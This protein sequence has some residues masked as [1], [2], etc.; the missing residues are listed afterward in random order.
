MTLFRGPGVRKDAT[1]GTDAGEHRKAWGNVFPAAGV[2]YGGTV[3]GTND[4]APMTYSLAAAGFALPGHGGGMIPAGNDGPITVSTTPAPA[5]GERID[6]VWVKHNDVDIDP[7]SDVVIGCT[8]GVASGSAVAPT[9]PVRALELARAT[10]KAGATSTLHANVTIASTASRA[11]VGS[12]KRSVPVP[13]RSGAFTST[14]VVTEH[15]GLVTCTGRFNGGPAGTLTAG[16]FTELGTIPPGFR[17]VDQTGDP[18]ELLLAGSSNL[19][20]PLQFQLM[21][22]GVLNVRTFVPN[23]SYGT[24][25]NF[26]IAGNTWRSA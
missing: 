8:Q 20:V 1:R 15:N 13:G 21:P 22:T 7:N 4:T 11:L 12:A 10:V 5:T 16:V 18:T 6:I 26:S 23:T 17:P 3:T 2:V 24:G 25:P 9:I 19:A 14:M